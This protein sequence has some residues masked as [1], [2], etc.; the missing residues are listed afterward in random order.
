MILKKFEKENKDNFFK[1]KVEILF[2]FKYCPGHFSCPLKVQLPDAA[3]Y[4]ILN[5]GVETA[6]LLKKHQK[7]CPFWP[8]PDAALPF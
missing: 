2:P 5:I 1:L 8:S 3:L 4:K 7:K 6:F